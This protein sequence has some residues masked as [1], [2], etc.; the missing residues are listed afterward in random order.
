M[1]DDNVVDL[2]SAHP[3]WDATSTAMVEAD[4][5]AAVGMPVSITSGPGDHVVTI[6]ANG[7]EGLDRL[8]AVL[9]SGAKAIDV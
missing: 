1:S 2:P 8:C 5:T 3:G 4:L 7:L 9:Q 6:R